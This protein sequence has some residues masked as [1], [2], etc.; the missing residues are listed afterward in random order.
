MEKKRL[1]EA[2]EKHNNKLLYYARDARRLVCG[3]YEASEGLNDAN[4]EL[5]LAMR[6]AYGK[7]YLGNI[8]PG[9]EGETGL[10]EYTGQK[11]YNFCCDFCIPAY[12]EELE[13]LIRQWNTDHKITDLNR[14]YARIEKLDG[15]LLIWS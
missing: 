10:A 14:I 12:D 7:V 9:M 4:R 5:I 13:T 3:V 11:L 8:N 6:S 2:R 15:S 1:Q